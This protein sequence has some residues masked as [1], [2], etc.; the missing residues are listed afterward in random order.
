M[1]K[2]CT[3]AVMVCIA[4]SRTALQ[5]REGHHRATT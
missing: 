4:L 1:A 3:V 2:C 5:W